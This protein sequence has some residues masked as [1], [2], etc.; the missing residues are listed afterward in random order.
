MGIL[1]KDLREIIYIYVFLNVY[2]WGHADKSS[3]DVHF[4][5]QMAMSYLHLP[6]KN[7]CA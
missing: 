4:I 7:I 5:N 3:L 2:I 6:Y 1:D